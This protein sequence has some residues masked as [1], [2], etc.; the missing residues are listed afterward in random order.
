MQAL[1]KPKDNM[2]KYYDKHYQRQPKYQVG[3][4]VL[5][6]TKNTRM[7]CPTKKLVLKLYGL[8]KI[9]ARAGKSAY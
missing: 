5:L 6:N 1:E 8:F 2:S 7:L 4:E 9:L 3:D